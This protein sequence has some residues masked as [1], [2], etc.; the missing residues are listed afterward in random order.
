MT[1]HVAMHGRLSRTPRL[2]TTM[3]GLRSLITVSPIVSQLSCWVLVSPTAPLL[4][5]QLAHLEFLAGFEHLHDSHP[6]N[7]DIGSGF[8]C[9]SRALGWKMRWRRTACSAGWCPGANT[10]SREQSDER[11]VHI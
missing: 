4:V 10:V 1:E 5:R 7:Y 9:E 11:T 8:T 2:S 6:P 3:S